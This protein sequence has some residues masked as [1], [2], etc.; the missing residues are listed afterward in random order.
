VCGNITGILMG[1]LSE[2]A[3]E[4]SRGVGGPERGEWRCTGEVTGESLAA[5]GSRS[6]LLPPP[7]TF[8][9]LELEPLSVPLNPSKMVC[10]ECWRMRGRGL[11]WFLP[12]KFFGL[13]PGE[14][15]FKPFHRS[16]AS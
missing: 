4:E 13:I 16:L 9:L 14:R 15:K 7:P 10:L 6:E 3:D 12:G 11:G 1:S 2:A 8:W 5:P